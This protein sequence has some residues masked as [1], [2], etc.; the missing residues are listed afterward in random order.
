MTEADLAFRGL[1]A[2]LATC[3]V[4]AILFYPTWIVLH[5]VLSKKLDGY[6]FKEPY[7][8]RSEMIN[9]RSFP[10]SLVKSINYIYLVAFPRWA[11][12]KRFQALNEDLPVGNMLTIVCQ[13]HFSLGLVGLVLFFILFIYLG[14]TVLL[15]A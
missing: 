1:L 14:I 4:V 12:R 7:F 9:Y 8:S 10:L 11:K 5:K 13:L 3:A 2:L 6:I 15:Y